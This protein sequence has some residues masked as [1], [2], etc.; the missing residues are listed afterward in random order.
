MFDWWRLIH[1]LSWIVLVHGMANQEL[2]VTETENGI[3]V[4]SPPIQCL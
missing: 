4:L 3:I 1:I 2:H